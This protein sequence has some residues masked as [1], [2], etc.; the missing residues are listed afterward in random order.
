MSADIAF[1]GTLLD[2]DSRSMMDQ[3][4]IGVTRSSVD[5]AL[6]LQNE[7]ML[8]GK[9]SM[10][11]CLQGLRAGGVDIAEARLLPDG[12]SPKIRSTSGLKGLCVMPTS[13]PTALLTRTRCGG[14]A[15]VKLASSR[16]DSPPW[17]VSD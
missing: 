4:K 7:Y 15:V 14:I 9:G 10:L 2:E 3:S 16:V 1:E 13:S 12:R 8:K 11:F 5:R 6:V 17:S